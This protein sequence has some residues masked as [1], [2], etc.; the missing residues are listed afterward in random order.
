MMI[1]L[2]CKSKEQEK[3]ELPW[4]STHGKESKLVP[5]KTALVVCPYNVIHQW[6]QEI[7]TKA[8]GISVHIYHGSNRTASAS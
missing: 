5:S 7:K 8:S 1:S 4:L 6:D 2:L 3:K